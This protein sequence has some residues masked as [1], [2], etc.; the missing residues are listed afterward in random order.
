MTGYSSFF[1]QG[2]E[3]AGTLIGLLFVAISLSPDDRQADDTPFPF[4]VQTAIAFAALIDALVVSIYTALLPGDSVGIAALAASI[5][6]LSTTA[7]P[8]PP[9]IPVFGPRPSSA[10]PGRHPFRRRRVPHPAPRTHPPALNS[11]AQ[12]G[13]LETQAVLVIVF[14]L[15]IAISRAWRLIGGHGSK[16]LS[17]IAET[18]QRHGADSASDPASSGS[19]STAADR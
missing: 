8:H 12:P 5:G 14:F 18:A 13:A 9:G 1:D 2:A 7:W 17:V 10:R 15:Y 19:R 6:G 11:A 4:R 3:V 16:L